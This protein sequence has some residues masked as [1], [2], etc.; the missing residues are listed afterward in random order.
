V[1][2]QGDEGP[3]AESLA[4]EER[5]H[6]ELVVVKEDGGR[7][8]ALGGLHD[9]FGEAAVD[10]DVAL[11]PGP[12]RIVAQVRRVGKIVQSVLDEPEQ[13][14]GELVV[15]QVVG[16][17]VVFHEPDAQVFHLV[18]RRLFRDLD[19][20]LALGRGDPDSVVLATDDRV[21]GGDEAAGSSGMLSFARLVAGER[22]GPPVRGHDGSSAFAQSSPFRSPTAYTPSSL[23]KRRRLSRSWRGLR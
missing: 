15:H 8:V 17:G 12:P 6:V 4:D 2:E 3:I 7:V 1:D 13:R 5:G 22:N 14:V 10:G 19:V 9:G 21:Q 20:L 18:G 16:L 23:A 11:L